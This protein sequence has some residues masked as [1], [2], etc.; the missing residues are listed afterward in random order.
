MELIKKYVYEVYKESS[1]TKAAQKLYISQPALSSAI[2]KYEKSLGFRIFDRSRNPL[3]LTSEGSVLVESIE[4]IIGIESEVEQQIALMKRQH[5]SEIAV[6]GSTSAAYYLIPKI[7]AV[8][9]KEYPS[10]QIRIDLG[11]L[12]SYDSFQKKLQSGKLDLV[13]DH[14]PVANSPESTVI[15]EEDM[16]A[17]LPQSAV[18]SDELKQYAI[19]YGELDKANRDDAK[20]VRDVSLFADV[21]FIAYLQESVIMRSKMNE[22]FGEYRT[23]P[24]N[25]MNY[26]NAIVHCNLVKEDVGAIVTTVSV[27]IAFFSNSDKV[28]YFL[29]DNEKA[30]RYIYLTPG[31]KS[32]HSPLVKRFVEIAEDVCK[33]L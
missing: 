25:V 29:I 2:A 13:I 17:I 24:V 30:K 16:V 10:V 26:R 14:I 5:K 6:G 31:S 20:R 19:T 28:S 32:L 11:N 8:F 22:I 9:H 21:P 23:V 27:A 4:S 1:F 7:C 33:N 15:C 3:R 12:N 18:V